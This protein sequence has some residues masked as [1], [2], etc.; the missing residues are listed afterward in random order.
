M[1]LHLA[2]LAAALAASSALLT[3]C[4]GSATPADLAALQ[5][6]TIGTRFEQGSV[7]VGLEYAGDIHNEGD[8]K[9]IS[10]TATYNGV[11]ATQID[12]GRWIP[13]VHDSL[14]YCEHPSFFFDAQDVESATI[15]IA[16]GTKT[17]TVDIPHLLASRSV[18]FAAPAPTALKDGD[19][20]SF[21]AQ[22]A[23]GDVPSPD[24][25][26][27]E[28]TTA[29]CEGTSGY[30]FAGNTTETAAGAS[31]AVR[32][33]LMCE[34]AIPAGTP[35]ALDLAVTEYVYPNVA[36]CDGATACAATALFT[37]KLHSTWYP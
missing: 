5:G 20:V 8:C 30:L 7:L 17:I 3:G 15:E 23:P 21:T 10:A 22:L 26:T 18:A 35:V 13:A 2:S 29:G 6:V 19:T 14:A 37:T 24:G 12:V 34:T 25:G 1:R 11:G 27:A 36:T 16:D 33:S 32:A 31:Y 28:G 9:S 4:S